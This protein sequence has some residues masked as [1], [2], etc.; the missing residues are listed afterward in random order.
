M[1]PQHFWQ[2]SHNHHPFAYLTTTGRTT[3]APHRIEIWYALEGD[4][5]YVMSGGRDRS[6]WVKNL[7][8]NPV[9]SI[10]IG[11]E[12]LAGVAH[13]LPE[14]SAHDQRAR[15]LLVGKYQKKDELQEW[16]RNSLG[17]LI[18]LGTRGSGQQTDNAL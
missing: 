8:A 7:M 6:D 17:V 9:V 1:S 15:Q 5:V 11:G 4:K 2:E 13:V 12:T 18:M 14:G 10:E 16:G 3:G